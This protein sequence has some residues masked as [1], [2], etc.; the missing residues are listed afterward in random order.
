MHGMAVCDAHDRSRPQ[1]GGML[2]PRFDILFFIFE[3]RLF[4]Q[5]SPTTGNVHQSPEI[6][7]YLG[8]GGVRG[9]GILREQFLEILP[10]SGFDL[11]PAGSSWP[12]S[13]VVQ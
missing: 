5:K 8:D 6:V 2:R 7:F 1:Y 13:R 3:K 12:G 4:L 10:E 11:F 9:A